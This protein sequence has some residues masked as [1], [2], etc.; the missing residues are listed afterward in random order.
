MDKQADDLDEDVVVIEQRDK[1]TYIYI[2]LAALL[3]IAIGGLIG[4]VVAGS[5]LGKLISLLNLII[6]SLRKRTSK[7]CRRLNK[8][9]KLKIQQI[10]TEFDQKLADEKEDYAKNSR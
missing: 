5:T 2:G 3:G 4:G 9:E 7:I 6:T 10:K 1:R 8:K